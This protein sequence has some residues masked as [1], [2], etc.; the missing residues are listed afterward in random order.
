MARLLQP[1]LCTRFGD[2]SRDLMEWG[3]GARRLQEWAARA[4]SLPSVAPEGVGGRGP[5][6]QE[7]RF[8]GVRCLRHGKEW[9]RVRIIRISS[10]ALA[11]PSPLG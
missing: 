4:S 7:R 2:P 1:L 6:H 9:P 11:I 5:L 8:W 3:R 10:I